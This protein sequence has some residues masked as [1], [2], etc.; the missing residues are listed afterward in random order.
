MKS[1]PFSDLVRKQTSVFPLLEDAD[2]L[3]ERRDAENVV[4]MRNDRYTAMDGALRIA[5]RSLSMVAKAN[6]EM[7]EEVFAEELP[8]LTWLPAEHRA[9]AVRELLD[10]L[11]AG[12][13]TGFYLPFM[14]ELIAWK[15]TAE[16]WTDPSVVADLTGPLDP[17]EFVEIHRPGHTG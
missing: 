5:A 12:A 1:L 17:A 6:R 14:R 16:I 10:N 4:L 11:L 7:A 13:D 2:V 9:E 15:H 3:L 8:W